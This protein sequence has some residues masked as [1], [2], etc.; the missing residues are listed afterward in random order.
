MSTKLTLFLAC[1]FAS[2][3]AFGQAT[4]SFE[5][6]VPQGWTDQKMQ[7]KLNADH[8]KDGSQSLQ[9]KAS[10]DNSLTFTPEDV[11]IYQKAVSLNLYSKQATN[12]T[13]FVDFMNGEVLSKR[14][15]ILL[16]FKGWRAVNRSF[17]QYVDNKRSEYTSIVFSLNAKAKPAMIL[18]D[19]VE[20]DAK[21]EKNFE[22][23]LHMAADLAFLSDSPML[24]NW[25]LNKPDIKVDKSDAKAYKA[26]IKKLKSKYTIKN[27]S[28]T[29][30][31]LRPVRTF[32]DSLG[33]KYNSDGTVVGKP[34]S[35]TSNLDK[36]YLVKASD[37]LKVLSLSESSDDQ[38]LSQILLDYLL[39][40]GIAEGMPFIM[41]YGDYATMRA[42]PNNFLL[43]LNACRK[44]QVEPLLNLVRW[45]T[46]YG[47]V[48]TPEGEY[49]PYINADAVTNMIA[50]YYGYATQ[51]PNELEQ[52]QGL[53]A[54][55][56]FLER[57]T[58]YV[59]GAK[60][61]LKVDGTGFHH[62]THYNG[63][64]YAINHWIN[65]VYD[66]KG[67]PLMI[68]AAS[69]GRIK[70]AVLS[71]YLL[72]PR[73]NN[74]D[75]YMANA[76]AGR[77]MFGRNGSR[78][79]V[80]ASGLKKL[81]EIGGA[82]E[83]IAFNNELAAAYNY[84]FETQEYA[85]PSVKYDGFY[86]FNYSPIGVYR[87]ASWVVTMRSPTTKFWGAE[88]YSKTNRFGRYQSH[89]T[90][91]VIYPGGLKNSGYPADNQCGGWDWNMAPGSTTVHYTNWKEMTPDENA[92]QRFDQF[93]ENSNYSGALSFG[94]FGVFSAEFDQ[95]DSWG[96]KCYTSTNL[97]FKKTVFAFDKMLVAIASNIESQGKYRNDRITATNLF[98]NIIYKKSS[99]I[100]VNDKIISEMQELN[101]N[102]DN[103][104]QFLV[105]AQS[106]GYIIRKGNDPIVIKYGAQKSPKHTAEDVDNPKTEVIAAKAYMRHGVKP[107]AKSYHY[108]VVPNTTIEELRNKELSYSILYQNENIHG[109]SVGNK[110]FYSVFNPVEKLEKGLLIN[111][112]SQALIIVEE[113]K[114]SL[115]LAV[116]NPNLNPIPDKK[117][118]WISTPTTIGISIRG[119]WKLSEA[120]ENVKLTVNNGQTHL[121]FKLKDGNAIYFSLVK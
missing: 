9:W 51:I 118:E 49:L 95:G 64:M 68:N 97:K 59:P 121:S 41:N 86:A 1:L 17:D 104:D 105:D 114:N 6:G 74:D 89:G 98:Q 30:A 117:F 111:S 50:I 25:A 52:I 4:F 37:A 8:Y 108:V 61:I 73:S 28:S 62:K 63:Y 10:S 79:Q 39:D 2:H 32:Y 35:I 23:G 100:Y 91:E 81:I 12:D 71:M 27:S 84:F 54:I 38:Q 65:Y 75:K 45:I 48:F 44:D 109:L 29:E 69:F 47:K 99:S 58:E 18:I 40:Q 19:Q 60:D 85:V 92:T 42:V 82:I 11:L 33:I 16:N 31:Q 5:S 72:V 77:N 113:K 21:I 115:S 53:K 88:I 120:V 90:L 110:T 94:Q 22:H 14:A 80:P 26:V 107:T 101:L 106:T 116:C 13:L 66:L 57:H 7:L 46:E 93:T 36:K 102:S 15:Q 20:L 55:T 43:A 78:I 83:G 24:L 119:V 70:K 87:D 96:K 34:I 112:E 3:I 56:R 76:L 67:S 103:D